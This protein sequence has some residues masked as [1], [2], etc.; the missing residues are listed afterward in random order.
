MQI[1][2]FKAF[3]GMTQGANLDERFLL[4]KQAGFHGVEHHVYNDDPAEVKDLVHKHGL[5]LICQIF[6]LT[7]EDF[8]AQAEKAVAAGAQSINSHTGRDKWSFDEGRKFFLDAIAI[9]NDLG[10]PINH[11]THRHRMLFCP[12]DAVRYLEALPDLHLVL[13]LSHWVC[14]T[15]SMLDD[16]PDWIALA[17]DRT[18]HVHARV[19]YPE[20]PQVPDPSAP[21]WR[22]QLQAHTAWWDAAKAAAENRGDDVMTVTPEF[23][24]VPYM[25][26]LPHTNQPV[27]DLWTVN[28]WMRDHLK[29]H[30][31]L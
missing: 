28:L 13:D 27:A 26:T 29:D 19:G 24:P 17:I 15:E 25:P 16:I 18:R 4:S 3:W 11:E 31:G 30:W 6:P 5:D 10:I 9:E 7:I 12:R 22:P 14:V 8:R 20:G 1:K 2:F 21:E 23:G